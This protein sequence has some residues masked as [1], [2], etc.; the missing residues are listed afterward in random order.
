MEGLAWPNHD[1]D[2]RQGHGLLSESRHVGGLLLGLCEYA[3]LW[4]NSDE[5]G[6]TL[7]PLRL[8]RSS[9]LGFAS[10]CEGFLKWRIT[11]LQTNR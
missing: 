6:A 9:D 11:V 10:H 7:Y 4:E 2:E 8:D 5:G 3:L 1:G